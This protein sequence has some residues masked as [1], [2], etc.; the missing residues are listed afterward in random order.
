MSLKIPILKL[1]FAINKE[2]Y[3]IRNR[4]IDNVKG[5]GII[6]VVLGHCMI[7]ENP[8]NRVIYSFHMPIFFICSGYVYNIKYSS[9]QKEFIKKKLKMLYD[10]FLIPIIIFLILSP[11]F[12]K[13]GFYNQSFTNLNN[14]LS[15]SGLITYFIKSLIYLEDLP[16]LIA[17]VWFIRTLFIDIILFNFLN[18]LMKNNILK[19]QLIISIIL[20]VICSILKYFKI[21]GL[22]L[23]LFISYPLIYFGYL[24]KKLNIIN[25]LS[26]VLKPRV[27][28]CL[29]SFIVFLLMFLFSVLYSNNIVDFFTTRIDSLFY[30]TFMLFGGLLA[31]YLISYT[32][33]G[34]LLEFFGKNSIKIL[35]IHGFILRSITLFLTN[36]LNIPMDLRFHYVPPMNLPYTLLYFVLTISISSLII[37][38]FNNFKK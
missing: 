11:L 19:K 38:I 8:I 2:C 21:E 12:F 24:L 9:M 14:Y 36:I 33:G 16:P 6:L 3:I 18:R 15:I 30:F 29:I 28:N 32:Y 25:R 34:K 1:L 20:L 10:Y 13:F 37:L 31:T 23:N 22:W 7:F 27:L 26:N 17:Q 4:V 35:I 5:F